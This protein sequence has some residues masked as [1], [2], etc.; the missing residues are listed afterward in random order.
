MWSRGI[1]LVYKLI[2]IW[3]VLNSSEQCLNSSEH[4][5][6]CRLCIVDYTRLY[7]FFCWLVG[8]IFH[9]HIPTVCIVYELF[10]FLLVDLM[11]WCRW[12]LFEPSL[13]Q[14]IRSFSLVYLDNYFV[15]FFF[16]FFL[17][18]CCDENCL[19][20]STNT[21]HPPFSYTVISLKTM[22]ADHFGERT[23][24]KPWFF[25]LFFCCF[26]CFWYAFFLPQFKWLVSPVDLSDSQTV[27][28]CCEYL[29]IK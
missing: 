17:I 1:S 6:V 28:V 22:F 11:R 21:E 5:N 16:T 29:P 27:W 14:W 18:L 7:G 4:Y 13:H 20:W 15:H 25:L 8:C 23:M 2:S 10:F 19:R 24:L 12:C 9:P 26:V 3:T